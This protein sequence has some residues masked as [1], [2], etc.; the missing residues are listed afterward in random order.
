MTVS[1]SMTMII[2]L[3]FFISFSSFNRLLS[4]RLDLLNIDTAVLLSLFGSVL[5]ELM[6]LL[7]DLLGLNIL[8]SSQLL[9]IELI[10]TQSIQINFLTKPFELESDFLE[11]INNLFTAKNF[12]VIH[13][14]D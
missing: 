5:S 3:R 2:S 7:E 1:V 10:A 8:N 14:S 12:L 13:T 11:N 9:T 4:A 6:P